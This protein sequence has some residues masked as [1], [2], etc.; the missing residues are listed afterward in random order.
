MRW[1]PNR[2]SRDIG[3]VHQRVLERR[4]AVWLGEDFPEGVPPPLRDLERA[5]ARVR[6]LFAPQSDL[7]TA[8]LTAE[9]QSAQSTS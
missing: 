7:R 2:L 3:L 6:A 1:G 4:H 9:T 5:L 8:K